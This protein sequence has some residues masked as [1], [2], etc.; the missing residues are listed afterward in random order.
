M[1][2]LCV[3]CLVWAL[4]VCVCVQRNAKG[5]KQMLNTYHS[6]INLTNQQLSH[7]VVSTHHFQSI[8]NLFIDGC[9]C[10]HPPPL[11]RFLAMAFPCAAEVS[12]APYS[13][14]TPSRRACTLHFKGMYH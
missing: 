11:S 4:G 14:N 5:N 9:V 1:P 10:V 8:G 3:L 13:Y 12:R 6:C 7:A 2:Y